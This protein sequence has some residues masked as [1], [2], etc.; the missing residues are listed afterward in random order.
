MVQT[1]KEKSEHIQGTGGF[2]RPDEVLNNIDIKRDMKIADFGCGA[3]Y[4]TMPL[5]KRIGEEGMVYAIDVQQSALES[6]EGRAR[7]NSYFNIETIR[8][9][10]E[11]KNGSRL[12]DG[13]VDMVMLANILFQSKFIDAILKEAKRVLQK[14]GRIVIIEWS[15]GAPLGPKLTNRISKEEL[16]QS[17]KD[18]GFVLEKEFNAG[19]SH[20]GLVF[21]L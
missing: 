18:A 20:Y 14:N 21:S 1:T 7:I 5:A 8:A 15:D 3:G 13:S 4:F 9:N 19:N 11:S 6:V 2:M 10:L 17:V 16:K 12:K